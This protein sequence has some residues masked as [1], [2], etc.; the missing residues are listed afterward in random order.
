[1]TFAFQGDQKM[2]KVLVLCTGN[3]CRSQMMH[4]YLAHF[5]ESQ[6]EVYSAGS[7][8]HEINRTAVQM[9]MEDGHDISDHTSNHIDEYAKINF[10]YFI[11]VCDHALESCPVPPPHGQHIHRAFGDPSK[12][13]GPE[14]V[15][16]RSFRLVRDEIKSWAENFVKTLDEESPSR[17]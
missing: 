16:L 8:P 15:V 1:M 2:K 9:M 14:D 17:Q 6:L 5:G 10:D 12:I 7:A 3:S 13:K 11:S 4:G